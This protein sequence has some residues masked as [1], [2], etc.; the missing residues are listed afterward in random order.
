MSAIV[1][2]AQNR[3]DILLEAFFPDVKEGFYVDVGANHPVNDS[4]TKR[5]Y[6][7]GW[8]GIN[9]E[10]N[11]KLWQL[12][13]HDRPRDINLQL[14]VSN[15]N[16]EFLFREY[17]NHGLSTF[18]SDMK[19]SYEKSKQ[20]EE[21]TREFLEYQ[22]PVTTLK[23]IFD[24]HA[25]G[26]PIH[27]LKI[28]I[29][30]YEYEA[31]EA[32]DWKKYRPMMICIE[33]NHIVRDWRPLLKKEGY[34][35]V[36]FDGLNDYY[37]AKEEMKRQKFFD[38]PQA[39]L[40]G[41]HVVTLGTYKQLNIRDKKIASLQQVIEQ[42]KRTL[43]NFR[44]EKNELEVRLKQRRR[45]RQQVKSLFG[46]ID[47]AFIEIIGALVR[48]KYPRGLTAAKV[49]AAKSLKAQ[50]ALAQQ[51]DY[52]MLQ[53]NPLRKGLYLLLIFAYRILRKVIKLLAKAA[54][55]L[56]KLLKRMIKR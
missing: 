54:W 5:F 33:S 42:Q 55:Y 32:N 17:K 30:G 39:T 48:Q 41:K 23:E 10:P 19:A 4:V 37:L 1:S 44:L 3:E 7:K 6:D 49:G 27:F 53:V 35:K 11:K 20:P 15:K 26:R 13:Q 36:F 2:Y 18:S 52:K 38:Y 29:E 56:I 16:G 9:I 28:D 50:L 25:K 46:S 24:D 34:E 14:G 40:V 31:L 47:R 21:G 43:Q 51:Y 45:I 12:L 22:V 8:R